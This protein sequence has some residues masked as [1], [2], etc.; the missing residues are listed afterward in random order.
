MKYKPQ[1]V[2]EDQ[3]KLYALH[4]LTAIYIHESEN[5]ESLLAF[6]SMNCI[7]KHALHFQVCLAFSSM[8][9]IFKYELHFQAF[10]KGAV[11]SP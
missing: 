5:V 3:T 11:E 2:N 9:C 7:F 4:I 6:S 8:P 1:E 10:N